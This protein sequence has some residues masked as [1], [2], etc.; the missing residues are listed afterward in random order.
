MKTSLLRLR[1]L[2]VVI[3]LIAGFVSAS[4]PAAQ[5]VAPK[6]EKKYVAYKITRGDTV[7]I[8]ILGEQ[9]L[10]A[11]GKR[12]EATGTINLSLIGE[13]NLVGLTIAEAQE[14]IAKKYRDGRP[15]SRPFALWTLFAKRRGLRSTTLRSYCGGV[16]LAIQSGREAARLG[17]QDLP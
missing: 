15:K 2:S 13:I 7:S 12:V 6:T 1:S 11:G 10:N 3:A 8:G 17:L 9:D 14:A 16:P 4:L 5:P